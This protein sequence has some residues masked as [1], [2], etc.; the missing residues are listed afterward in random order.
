MQ[1]VKRFPTMSQA[2]YR[3]LLIYFSLLKKEVVCKT[4]TIKTKY[5]G[6]RSQPYLRHCNW[7][8]KET[9]SNYFVENKTPKQKR[10]YEEIYDIL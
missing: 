1:T 2:K 4:S 9:V 3:F 8:W 7:I 5:K 6:L 10:N